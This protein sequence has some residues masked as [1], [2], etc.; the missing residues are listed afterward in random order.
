[1]YCLECGNEA[2]GASKFCPNCGRSLQYQSDVPAEP[3]VVD[4][5]T[6]TPGSGK[7]AGLYAKKNGGWVTITDG[8]IRSVKPGHSHVSTGRKVAGIFC[9]IIAALAALQGAAWVSGWNDLQT[10]GNQFAGILAPLFLGAF[11]VAAGFGIGGYIL[12]QGRRSR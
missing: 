1:M 3:I 11:A 12:M 9:Y 8:E 5:V 10:N 4:G 7:F 6:Y 2:Q